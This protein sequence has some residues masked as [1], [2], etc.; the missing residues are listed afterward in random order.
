M[1]SQVQKISADA[2][3]IIAI[4][5]LLSEQ[6]AVQV[7]QLSEFFGLD[8]SAM[9]GVVNHLKLEG[10][11]VV[12]ELLAGQSP[13]VSVTK[14]GARLAG[15]GF[16]ARKPSIASLGHRRA[17]NEARLFMAERFPDGKWICERELRRNWQRKKVRN[18]PDGVFEIDDERWAIEVE[19]S[20]K[21]IE[22]LRE[23]IR[24]HVAHYDTVVYLCSK[25][26]AGFIERQ[27][28]L[29]EFPEKLL[30]WDQFDPVR[31]LGSARLPAEARTRSPCVVRRSPKPSEIP[32][33]DLLAEQGAIPE[34][35]LARFLKCDSKKAARLGTRLLEAGLVRCSRPLGN[36]GDWFWLTR[37]GAK[38]STTDLCPRQPKVGGL[39]R[40]RALNEIRLLLAEQFPAARWISDRTMRKALGAKGALPGAVLEI[41]TASGFERRAI[42]VC[43][44]P[45]A[46]IRDRMELYRT[47]AE[48][49]AAMVFC[50]PHT[51]GVTRSTA[52]RCGWAD[53]HVHLVPDSEE[54]TFFLDSSADDQARPFKSAELNAV[55]E[56]LGEAVADEHLQP[57]RARSLAG[58]LLLLKVGMPQGARRTECALKKDCRRFGLLGDLTTLPVSPKR[59]AGHAIP[60]DLDE[61]VECARQ[62]VGEG[63]LPPSRARTVVGF[64]LLKSV[65][66]PQGAERTVYD[67]ERAY[68]ELRS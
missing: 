53:L 2:E 6:Q 59:S 61:V 32:V 20:R 1:P 58:Y 44:S 18:I 42:D 30:V 7:D 43:L 13:W 39:G 14:R 51:E 27:G 24:E 48:Y 67:L 8:V 12:E 26:V 66:V 16:L 10:L 33:L 15:T 25:D 49:D 35:Q 28:L 47:S 50:T 40:R 60:D 4:L 23:N 41:E 65:G 31:A 36:E 55:I 57:S 46:P 68:S 45:K 56:R 9:A 21:V 38:A 34:D 62:K 63:L 64:F 3:K 54:Y 29:N 22:A 11:A 52:E 19:L 17:I 37:S 5:H